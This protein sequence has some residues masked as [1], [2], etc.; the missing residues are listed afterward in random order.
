METAVLL[1]GLRSARCKC[2]PGRLVPR[3][4][5]VCGLGAETTCCRWAELGPCTW[6]QVKRARVAGAE[7]VRRQQVSG[8]ARGLAGGTR[9][10]PQ[11]SVVPSRRAGRGRAGARASPPAA[12]RVL[13]GRRR[14]RGVR[15][16]ASFVCAF[17]NFLPLY[18]CFFSSAE[19]A[20]V[21]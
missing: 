1:A 10:G 8:V 7:R 6:C 20:R 18:F 17:L 16:S 5:E 11:R 9:A 2:Q 12:R 4:R 19:E 3:R 13:A 15:S 14:R 21:R